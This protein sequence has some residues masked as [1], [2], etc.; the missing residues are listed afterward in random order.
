[1]CWAYQVQAVGD[2]CRST[3][4]KIWTV[5]LELKGIRIRRPYEQVK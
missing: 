1:M 2:A 4:F 5:D 3:C